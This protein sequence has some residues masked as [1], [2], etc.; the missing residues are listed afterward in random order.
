MEEEFVPPVV[1]ARAD[2]PKDPAGAVAACSRRWRWSS[3]D[4][5]WHFIA[6]LAQQ[7]RFVTPDLVQALYYRDR[8]VPSLQ[9]HLAA[10]YQAHWLDRYGWRQL[11][12]GRQRWVYALGALGR[13][14]L[15]QQGLVVRWKSVDPNS[16]RPLVHGL[17]L[18]WAA[19]TWQ[20]SA[21]KLGWA[22]TDWRTELDYSIQI[23]HQRA[24]RKWKPDA[25]FLLSRGSETVGIFVEWD[26]GTEPL[27]D[28]RTHKVEPS[29]LLRGS[30]LWE[31]GTLPVEYWVVTRPA[32]VAP[33]AALVHTPER[34]AQ[35]FGNGSRWR[36]IGVEAPNWASL[37]LENLPSW[38]VPPLPFSDTVVGQKAR[39]PLKDWLTG[40]PPHSVT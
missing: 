13:W 40:V 6:G 7:W 5:H 37:A 26:R 39:D 20:Q 18:A 27:V 25:H 14:W 1:R 4:R 32:R 38:H 31:W 21:V 10:L 35:P 24:V 19:A 2:F 22:V 23:P 29:R 15:R 3:E 28:F 30:S 16:Y 34:Y 33:I 12:R 11:Q 8:T 36:I 9:H 17:E